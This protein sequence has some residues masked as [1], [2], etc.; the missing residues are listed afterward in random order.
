MSQRNRLHNLTVIGGIILAAVFV[1]GFVLYAVNK[2]AQQGS[3]RQ[4]NSAQQQTNT[5]PTAVTAARPIE[6]DWNKPQCRNAKS[7]DEADLCEQRRMAEAAE[8]SVFLSK[9][10]IGIGIGGALLLFWTLY[11]SRRA[12]VRLSMP[13]ELRTRPMNSIDGCSTPITGRGWMRTLRLL[14]TM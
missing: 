5:S 8:D 9:I 14:A 3:T 2:P 12:A 6:T 13:L 10:Q 4:S 1:V 11:E 7:H